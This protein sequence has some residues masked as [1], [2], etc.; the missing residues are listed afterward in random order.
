MNVQTTRNFEI[1][2]AVAVIVGLAVPAFAQVG[3]TK[4]EKREGGWVSL[5]DGTEKN[6]KKG[7][8]VQGLEFTGPKFHE[9]EKALWF[10]NYDWWALITEKKYKNFV[11]RFDVMFEK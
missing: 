2:L 6:L 8:L 10:R 11:L 4:A 3:L 7:W 9:E 1:A 5:F